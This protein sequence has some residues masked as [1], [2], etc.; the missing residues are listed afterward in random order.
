MKRPVIYTDLDGSLLD[1]YTYEATAA[2]PLLRQLE[3]LG[4]PVIPCTSKTAAAR[5]PLCK[6]L[7]LS[8]PFI[9][10]NGALICVPTN[11]PIPM[12]TN[13]GRIG[14]YWSHSFGYPR[15]ALRAVLDSL[16]GDW[17]RC[18][19]PLVDLSVEDVMSL[20]QLDVR[21]AARAQRRDFT[22]TLVWRGSDVEFSK[23]AAIVTQSGL[24]CVRGGRFVHLM[25]PNTKADAMAWL[26]LAIGHYLGGDLVSIGIGDADNDRALLEAAD[27]ALLIRSPVHAFPSLERKHNLYFSHRCGPEGW[28]E[29]VQ[30]I[31]RTLLGEEALA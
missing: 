27:H 12:P 28:T 15:A 9:A 4:T 19:Q 11:W 7:Q 5:V 10:E 21:A 13:S 16:S 22:E 18:Y 17:Q 8:G 6:T 26:Q 23:F 14:A 2:L 1:H 30:A 24:Q 29:G 31:L 3:P 25:G 20:T